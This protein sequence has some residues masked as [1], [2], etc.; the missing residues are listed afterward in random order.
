MKIDCLVK[1]G[2]SLQDFG[3]Y[4]F[5]SRVLNRMRRAWRVVLLPGG[6][7]FADLIR[8]VDRKNRL[9]QPLPHWMSILAMEQYGFFL[10]SKLKHTVPVRTRNEMDEA[11]RK[12]RIPIFL[13]FD[14]L[15]SRDEVPHSWEFTSDSIAAYLADR[16][17][18]PRLILLK[19]IDG[20]FLP[21]GKGK[22][23]VLQGTVT[24]KDLRNADCVDRFFGKTLKPGIECWVINGR[25][26]K[27]LI[28]LIH[29]GGTIGTRI[30]P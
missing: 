25:R 8:E 23:P 28:E 10:T 30:V 5:L 19:V 22:R 11:F 21:A 14:F 9:P 20:V 16:F 4:E 12:R 2:G 1:I 7:N 29:G 26:P 6:S 24:R 18:I 3:E 27:R 15:Y 13:P 17:R